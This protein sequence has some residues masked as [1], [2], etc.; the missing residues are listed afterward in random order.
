MKASI[1]YSFSYDNSKQ[2]QSYLYTI[3][4][5]SLVK[6]PKNQQAKT[7]HIHFMLIMGNLLVRTGSS[8][9]LLNYAYRV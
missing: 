6:K 5:S 8:E 9:A 3:L 4:L 2:R 1:S 7:H